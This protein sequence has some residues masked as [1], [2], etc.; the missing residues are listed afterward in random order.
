MA[1]AD[2]PLVEAL[3]AKLTYARERA[4]VFRLPAPTAPQ[5]VARAR[6]LAA[7]FFGVADPEPVRDDCC[8]TA[9]KTVLRLPEGAS[10]TAYHASGALLAVRR[11]EPFA[12]LLPPEA[13]RESLRARA[14]ETAT[15]LRLGACTAERERLEFERLWLVRANG[16][17]ARGDI[18]A[19]VLCR[20]VGA[21]R[22]F[23][24][25]LPVYGRA[26]V[27]VKLAG[28]RTVAAVGVDWRARATDAVDQARLIEPKDAAR[29]M[30]GELAAAMPGRQPSAKE[31]EPTLFAVGYFSLPKRRPQGYLQPV[32]VATF[33]ARGGMTLNRLIVLPAAITP[34]ESFCRRLAAAPA[35]T[36]K[37]SA[38]SKTALQ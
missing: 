12:E 32:Y 26:S 9:D 1:T 19:P 31:Y 37:A 4:P 23:V 18:G 20:A 7:R 28:E 8:H 29:R 35:S 13:T 33:E 10:V 30:V 5:L 2:A 21:F 16:I 17:T 34:Y 3:L 38:Q 27:F 6:D 25:D 36:G 15:A 22:R 11:L 14:E 24:D